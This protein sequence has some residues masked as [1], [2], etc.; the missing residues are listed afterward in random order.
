MMK[1]VGTQWGNALKSC[2][3]NLKVETTWE[4]KAY[5]GR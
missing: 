3:E 5:A 4:S 1:W 2:S